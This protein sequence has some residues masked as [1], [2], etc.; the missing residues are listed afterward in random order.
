MNGYWV[1]YQN[2]NRLFR[3]RERA[4]RDAIRNDYGLE[5][6]LKAAERLREAKIAVFNSRFSG[7]SVLPAHLFS[8]ED[9]I[10]KDNAVSKWNSMTTEEIVAEYAKGG[11]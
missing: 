10:K 9:I 6:V 5:N 8:P 11:S 4:L 1:N 7:K 3:L 2:K